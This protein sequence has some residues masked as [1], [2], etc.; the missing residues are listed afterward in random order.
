MASPTAYGSY[1][2]REPGIESEMELQPVC[3]S[4]GNVGSFSP[5]PWVRDRTRASVATRFLTHCTTAGAGKLRV[6]MERTQVL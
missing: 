1:W 2:A 3:H 4:C 5:L 6:L